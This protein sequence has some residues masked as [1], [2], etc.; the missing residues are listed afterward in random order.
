MSTSESVNWDVTSSSTAGNKEVR[1]SDSSTPSRPQWQAA[2]AGIHE[3]D[4]DEDYSQRDFHSTGSLPGDDNQDD[5]MQEDESSGTTDDNGMRFSPSRLRATPK[6]IASRQRCGIRSASP[7]VRG[8]G[9]RTSPSGRELREVQKPTL[10]DALRR[11]LPRPK[12]STASPTGSEGAKTRPLTVDDLPRPSKGTP[13]DQAVSSGIPGSGQPSSSWLDVG[14]PR[15]KPST[16]SVPEITAQLSMMEQDLKVTVDNA[17]RE[18]R[19]YA[20]REQETRDKMRTEVE[21]I[22]GIAQAY[23]NTAFGLHEST[24]HYEEVA[25]SIGDA[26]RQDIDR[27]VKERLLLQGECEFY[28][29]LLDEKDAHVSSLENRTERLDAGH[30]ELHNRQKKQILAIQTSLSDVE[31][32]KVKLQKQLREAQS[33]SGLVPEKDQKITELEDK[34]NKAT[35]ESSKRQAENEK[36][37]KRMTDEIERMKVRLKTQCFD[38]ENERQK[39]AER[40]IEE[41]RS[42][43]NKLQVTVDLMRAEKMQAEAEKEKLKQQLTEQEFVECREGV[44]DQEETGSTHGGISFAEACER[45]K[46]PEDPRPKVKPRK[47]EN[48]IPIED[49]SHQFKR[50]DMLNYTDNVDGNWYIF[51]PP[52]N[53]DTWMVHPNC[54]KAW[55][56]VNALVH[57]LRYYEDDQWNETDGLEACWCALWYENREW[58][59]ISKIRE[60]FQAI[61]TICEGGSPVIYKHPMWKQTMKVVIPWIEKIEKLLY[62]GLARQVQ[63]S[64]DQC[65]AEAMQIDNQRNNAVNL[66]TD[67]VRRAT[68][69]REEAERNAIPLEDPP[70]EAS[71]RGESWFRPSEPQSSDREVQLAREMTEKFRKRKEASG[72]ETDKV[73]EAREIS[74]GD[75]EIDDSGN[76]EVLSLKTKKEIV[77]LMQKQFDEK[78]EDLLKQSRAQHR[79]EMRQIKERAQYDEWEG[80]HPE[81]IADEIGDEDYADYW[82]DSVG[83][84]DWWPSTG[85]D[86]EAGDTTEVPNTSDTEAS[87]S[88]TRRRSGALKVKGNESSSSSSKRDNAMAMILGAPSAD[89]N[90]TEPKRETR[91]T[92]RTQ[93]KEPVKKG[94]LTVH[95]KSYEGINIGDMIRIQKKG[96]ITYEIRRVREFGSIKV[97][98]PFLFDYDADTEVLVVEYARPRL[99]GRQYARHREERDVEQ[100]GSTT[101][102]PTNSGGTAANYSDSSTMTKDKTIGPKKITVPSLPKYAREVP[103]FMLELGENILFESKRHDKKEQEFAHEVTLLKITSNRLDMIPERFAK[104]DRALMQGIMERVKNHPEVMREIKDMKQILWTENKMMAARRALAMVLFHF[105]TDDLA[106]ESLTINAITSLKWSNYGDEKAFQFLRDWMNTT[107]QLDH[108]LDDRHLRDMLYYNLQQSTALK[109]PMLDYTKTP[110]KNRTYRQLIEIFRTWLI[111]QREAKNVEKARQGFKMIND[112]EP[113]ESRRERRERA[114]LAAQWNEGWQQNDGWQEAQAQEVAAAFGRGKAKGSRK[115]K[116]KG[117]P[118]GKDSGKKGKEKGKGK[119]KKNGKKGKGKNDTNK[120]GGWQGGQGSGKGGKYGYAA[121]GKE[122]GKKGKGKKATGETE[123]WKSSRPCKFYNTKY[124][125]GKTCSYGKDCRFTHMEFGSQKEHDATMAQ[126]NTPTGSDAGTAPGTPRKERIVYCRDFDKCPGRPSG[127]DGSC[128]ARHGPEKQILAVFENKGGPQGSVKWNRKRSKSPAHKGGDKT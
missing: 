32:E 108:P 42:Q 54:D 51:G 8:S 96:E 121:K 44:P 67:R 120:G 114:W 48:G 99:R 117:E 5:A 20:Q 50:V 102:A 69:V 71:P 2:V 112:G 64:I 98:K 84:I 119:G 110:K 28:A 65:S 59:K 47:M 31:A 94:D 127:G 75:G 128:T 29:N 72:S 109:L 100:D 106:L 26:A 61:L 124:N 118:K 97:D 58:R 3:G 53:E 78:M 24:Q 16:T 73:P 116:E 74:A 80:V 63:N 87:L 40:I 76:E 30:V 77:D 113:K 125:G 37:A 33:S 107:S 39:E 46:S 115:G 57:R 88:R 91:I 15:V 56:K 68:K 93:L 49:G 122:K 6:G 104:F 23:A 11:N 70:R 90:K 38:L 13:Y 111:Q 45:P 7:I 4:E 18:K 79:E 60:M 105:A 43:V 17:E 62:A 66:R 126:N 41:K 25:K 14:S 21:E 83:D 27:E 82:E 10:K 95:L 85:E 1:S 103:N 86:K 9:S 55:D 19:N 81:E 35:I 89:R 12:P 101:D 34:L 22:T 123:N 36:E 92:V 52:A